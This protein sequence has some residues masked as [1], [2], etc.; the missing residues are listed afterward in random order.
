MRAM[1]LD[2]LVP[3]R[4]F[5]HNLEAE[6]ARTALEAAGIPAV[7]QRDDCG[8]IRPSLWVSGIQLLVRHEDAADADEILSATARPRPSLVARSS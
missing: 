6:I 2:H 8:G 3:V 1:A 5:V 7:L 4:I